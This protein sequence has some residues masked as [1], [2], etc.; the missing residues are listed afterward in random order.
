VVEAPA[1][2][3]EQRSTAVDLREQYHYVASDLRRI[4]ILAAAIL[5]GLVILSFIL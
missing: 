4:G 1:R 5:S 2:E 3:T